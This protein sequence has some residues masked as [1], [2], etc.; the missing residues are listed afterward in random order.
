MQAVLREL[1]VGSRAR[2]RGE[3]AATL[4][5]VASG[6][7]SKGAGSSLRLH[8]LPWFA[9]WELCP[10]AFSIPAFPAVVLSARIR[11]YHR[12]GEKKASPLKLSGQGPPR[13]KPGEG[14]MH[15]GHA[16]WE[17]GI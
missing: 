13:F 2:S 14:N 9:S 3:I 12:A 6:R 7:P 10:E 8:N 1:F 5:R 17:I 15:A 16:V 4:A 11:K